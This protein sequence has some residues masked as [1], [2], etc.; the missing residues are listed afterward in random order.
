MPKP[1]PHIVFRPRNERVFRLGASLGCGI[2]RRSRRE[3]TGSWGRRD[4]VDR[5]YI[6]VYI[7]AG[8]GR[9]EDARG[10]VLAIGPGTLY[11]RFPGL[12]HSS[13]FEASEDFCECYLILPPQIHDLMLA[14]GAISPR[15]PG[16]DIGVDGEVCGRFERALRRLKE[17]GD[18]ELP[19][20]LAEMHLFAA[21]LLERGG[22]GGGR[23]ADAFVEKARELLA[24]DASGRRSLEAVAR[25]LG[26]SYS[27]FRQDF[28]ERCGVSPGEFRQAKRLERAQALLAEAGARIK[29][30][31]GA[32][33]YPDVYSFSKQFKR[34]T[35][36]TP[37]AFARARRV[38]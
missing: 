32:L 14:A 6:L 33:G 16:C 21:E 18:A 31:A 3:M 2:S 22:S 36:F 10:N 20:V 37:G 27:K 29:D 12:R 30:V 9:Y 17:C 25:S 11:Q 35:G 1:D 19:V 38:G 23:E 13:V 34:H 24:R 8:R 28:R 4:I 26:M 15:R 5:C 7:V